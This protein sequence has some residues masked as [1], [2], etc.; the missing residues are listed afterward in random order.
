M[1]ISLFCC[2]LRLATISRGGAENAE[3]GGDPANS[4]LRLSLFILRASA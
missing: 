1:P 4:S 2:K 3:N